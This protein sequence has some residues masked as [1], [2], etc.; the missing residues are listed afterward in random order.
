MTSILYSATGCVR[1]ATIRQL[2]GDR[3]LRYREHDALGEGRQNFREFYQSNR[4]EIFRGPEGIEFPIFFDGNVI[5]QGLPMVAAHL[6]VGPTL[7]GFFSRGVR[8]GQWV[9]GIHISDGDP[10]CGD[11][12]LQVL[13]YLKER[14]F[15][16]QIDTNGLNADLLEAVF[17]R[18]LADYA[19][20]EVKGPVD[21]YAMI[22]QQ[23]VDPAEIAKSMAV[24]SKFDEYSFFTTIAPVERQS[25][26]PEQISYITPE[27][28]AEAA[29]LI[30]TATGDSRQ[31]YRLKAF[32]PGPAEDER[33][34]ALEKL[35]Q[36]ELLKY[37]TLA[38]RH[39]FKTEISA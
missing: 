37:R 13:T 1:C 26:A 17:E 19:V 5:L 35:T 32:D 25:G 22:L 31:P 21:L 39:Q 10:G 38:R 7:K 16:I 29:N 28:V 27:E 23:P 14:G 33:I 2:L 15:K 34:K 11:D 3:G 9:D 24:V 12:F 4:K 30:K 6:I 20:M 36:S 18:H 8:H